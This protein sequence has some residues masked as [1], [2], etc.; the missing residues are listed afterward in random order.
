MQYRVLTECDAVFL[1]QIFSTPEYDL[2][3]AENDTTE[4]DWKERLKFYDTEYSYI[5][6]KDDTDIGWIMYTICDNICKLDIV[7]LLSEERNK[8][9]GKEIFKD[10]FALNP[11]VRTIM[12]DVQQRNE[13]AVNFY[14]KIGFQITGEET[15]LVNEKNVPYFNMVLNL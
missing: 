11:Q 15:Q 6:L 5:I 14:K 9:Y 3:F 7:V 12:L 10:L 2:Y 8:G 4:D 13:Q 1:T